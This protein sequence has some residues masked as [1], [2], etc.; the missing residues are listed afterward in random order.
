MERDFS[1]GTS[2]TTEPEHAH[3]CPACD[4]L[5][6]HLTPECTNLTA[7]LHAVPSRLLATLALCPQHE[8]ESR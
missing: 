4:D 2:E 6:K 5:W 7:R 1:T 8:E 3:F